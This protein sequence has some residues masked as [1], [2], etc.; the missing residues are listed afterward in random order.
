MNAYGLHQAI[1]FLEGRS[2]TPEALARWTILELRWPLLADLLVAH[3]QLIT[4]LGNGKTPAI[5]SIPGELKTLFGDDEVK[6]VIG[7]DDVKASGA[8]D[9]AAIREIVG[10]VRA[11]ATP[12]DST[13]GQPPGTASSQSPA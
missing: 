7:L 5:E 3:P 1:F 8:L 4:D 6:G 11:A 2:I 9:E 13:A 10:L 12:A